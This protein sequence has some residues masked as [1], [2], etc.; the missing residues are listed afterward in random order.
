MMKLLCGLL[1]AASMVAA[2]PGRRGKK[3]AHFINSPDNPCG[4]GNMPTS[5]TCEDGSSPSRSNKCKP[6]LC[7]C[8]DNTTFNPEEL[9]KHKIEELLASDSNPCGAGNNP[10]CVCRDG[11][12]MNIESGP[13]CSGRGPITRSPRPA[14]VQ[15]VPLSSLGNS[16]IR[17]SLARNNKSEW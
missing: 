8:E 4:Q 2:M 7:T 3:L 15:M 6:T 10:T 11:S 5:C 1:I 13:P 14:R 17:P 12:P 9:M 16:S